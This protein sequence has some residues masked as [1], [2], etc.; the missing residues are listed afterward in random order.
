[1]FFWY[2]Q[3]MENLIFS[4]NA[5]M[6]IFLVMVLGYLFQ[7]INVIDLQLAKGMNTFVFKI[8]LPV[9]LFVQLHD[10]DFMGVWDTSYVVYCFMT[11][12]LSVGIAWGLS[13]LVR[14]HHIRGEVVQSSY[15]SSASLLGMAYIENIY[16][17]ASMGSLMMLGCVPLYNIMA[18]IILSVMKPG[19]EGVDR[20]RLK[21]SAKGILK[22]PIIWGILLGFAWSLTG[23]NMPKI[24]NTTLSY[25][26]RLASPMGLLAMGAMLDFSTIGK[27]IGPVL[28]A[29]F[30]KLIG[31][32]AA[33]L[34]V[35]VWMGFQGE[36]LVAVLIMLGS[37]ST[38]AGFVMAKNMG[39]EGNV[40]AGAVALTTLLSAFTLTFWV[41]LLRSMG[42]L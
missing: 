33:F 23:I 19:S 39:H 10:V 22:N 37:A 18:V 7:R 42:L 27:R 35:A 40:C 38:V 20:I 3:Y 21:S 25:I 4:L 12:L 14:D 17:T 1:M 2:N 5:T 34:P 9:N 41:W 31:F 30:L 6:P 8:A 36:K 16:G 29:S 32:V 11:T 26:G 24:A 15:R 28:L 13:F